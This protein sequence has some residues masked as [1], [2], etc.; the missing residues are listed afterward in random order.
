M[1]L[2]ETLLQWDRDLLIALNG[3]GSSGWDQFWLALSGKWTALP[4]YLALL[5]WAY[6]TLGWKRTL[7]LLGAIGLRITCTD[8]LSN[9]FKYGV[10]RLRPCHDP[11]LEGMIRLVKASCGGR[12]GYFS[13]HAANAM[14]VAVFFTTLWGR[15]GWR[16]GTLLLVWAL[17]VGYSRI[18]LGVH[19][20]LD[21]LTGMLAGSFFGLLFA[22]LHRLAQ[23]KWMP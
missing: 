16:W 11:A 7:L 14:A 15:K 13:A 22:R 8:Q 18:Y 20:P 6:R 5:V 12:Y 2:W 23:L 19:Y 1:E 21:V 4:L 3:W 17:L 9:L 10:G